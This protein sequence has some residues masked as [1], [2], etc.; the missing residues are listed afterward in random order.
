MSI[1][2]EL[3]LTKYGRSCL[4]QT[5]EQGQTPLFYAVD[6]LNYE[7][8]EYLIN[9]GV[10]VDRPGLYKHIS[11]TYTY[12]STIPR[13]PSPLRISKHTP[14][15]TP[16]K[17]SLDDPAIL[18]SKQKQ[19]NRP[20]SSQLRKVAVKQ[21]ERKQQSSP[22]SESASQQNPSPVVKQGKK[23]VIVIESSQSKSESES[24]SKSKSQPKSRSHSHSHSV[25]PEELMF[26]LD[27]ATAKQEGDRTPRRLRRNA[28]LSE[29]QSD[30]QALAVESAT[31]RK[32]R[33]QLTFSSSEDDDARVRK[34]SGTTF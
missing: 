18:G 29:K 23:G 9:A 25:D 16:N 6:A 8:A 14:Y 34:Q 5:D 17:Q 10:S 19:H 28:E 31:A 12:T 20:S 33:R 22:E 21:T 24:E 13:Q 26:D 27:F 15:T 4:E 7:T 3:V 32:Y 1:G 30:S 11:Q 2:V